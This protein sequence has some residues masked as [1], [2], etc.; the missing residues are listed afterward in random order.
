MAKPHYI[1]IDGVIG[2]GKTTLATIL[3]ER[4]HADLRLEEVEENPFLSKFYSDMRAY[5]FQTQLFFLLSRY[6]QQ[7]E[8]TQRSLFAEKVVSDYIFAKDRIF[9]YINLNDDE[10]MLYEKI[11]EILE[12]NI[13][14]PDIV[15][16]LQASTDVL[17]ERIDPLL[18]HSRPLRLSFLAHCFQLA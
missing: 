16:Y 10:L 14:S 3:A 1:G 6:R 17:M 11:V 2:V 4:L 8:L 13:I 5:A 15:I 12:K 18:L 7:S 9:A